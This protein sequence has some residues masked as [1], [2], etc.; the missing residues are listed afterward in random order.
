MDELTDILWSYRTTAR[1]PIG[2]SPFALTYGTEAILPVEI[3]LPS[4]RTMI[5]NQHNHHGT[6]LLAKA[7]NEQALRE[8]LDFLEEKRERA[9]V[10]TADYQQRIKQYFSKNVK[11]RTFLLGD[12]VLRRVFPRSKDLREGKLSPNWEGPYKVVR[13]NRPGTFWLEGLD[14]KPIPRPWNAEHLRKYHA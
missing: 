11:L 10:R 9:A 2:E 12:L 13:V 3:G 14:G 6:E 5:S 7:D 4:A 8:N 1:T